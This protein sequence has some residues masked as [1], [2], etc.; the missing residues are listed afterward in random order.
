VGGL[1]HAGQINGTTGYEEAAAQG[2]V[3]G[4]NAALRAGGS[5]PVVFGREES[6][7][8]LLIDDLVTRGVDEPYRMFTSRSELRLLLRIDNADRRLSPLGYKLGLLPVPAYAEFRQKYDEVERLRRFLQGHGFDPAEGEGSG[9]LGKLDATA[10]KGI[11]LEQLLKRPEITLSDF[12]GIIR[13]HSL[14]F[15]PAVRRSVEIEVRYEGYIRQQ[16]REAERLR[17]L[18]GRRIPADIDYASIDGLS[19]EIREKLAKLQPRDLGMAGR[20]PGMTPAALSILNLQLELR[21][22]R[23]VRD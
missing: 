18:G 12:E 1:F 16:E 15:S 3:A 20:I 6:Y 17:D 4:I 8:G 22:A 11:T 2:I 14:W 21:H 19:R 7:I 23:R 13:K 5:E 9:I 10:N